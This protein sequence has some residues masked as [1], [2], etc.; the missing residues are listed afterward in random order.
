MNFNNIGYKERKYDVIQA[1]ATFSKGFVERVIQELAVRATLD[2]TGAIEQFTFLMLKNSG[3][4]EEE[5]EN[6]LL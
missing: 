4:L 6:E 2:S 3:C 1:R 5:N